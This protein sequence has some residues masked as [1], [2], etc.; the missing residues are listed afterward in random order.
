MTRLA[1]SRA[2]ARPTDV[3]APIDAVTTPVPPAKPRH[4]APED[5]KQKAARSR[6]ANGPSV[7]AA[8]TTPAAV[9]VR[10]PRNESAGPV[11]TPPTP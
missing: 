3:S 9:T 5:P 2:M 10:R 4:G 1:L 11:A 6:V 8:K 7:P